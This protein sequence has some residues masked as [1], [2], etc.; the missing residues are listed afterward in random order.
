MDC[1]KTESERPDRKTIAAYVNNLHPVSSVKLWSGGTAEVVRSGSTD[2]GVSGGVRS[3]IK[4]I[5]RKSLARLLFVAREGNGQWRS[6]ITLT[7]PAMFPDNGTKVKADLNRFL[8]WYRRKHAGM[9]LW[10][11]EFQRRGAPHIHMLSEVGEV[12]EVERHY[13]SKAWV[14]AIKLGGVNN[15][16]G[17]GKV[18]AD[19]L[20]QETYYVHSRRVA[21]ED[22]RTEDGAVRYVTKY[23]LKTYQKRVP[24]EFR[25][26]GRFWGCS[27]AVT[28]G[29]TPEL[30][31]EMTDD[32]L[33]AYL[34]GVGHRT[35]EWDI[36]PRY[37]FGFNT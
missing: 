13:F 23:A 24:E 32:E 8:A 20:A 17:L 36:L 33:R 21:W 2:N 35:A 22:V 16:W 7:Y 5:T 14:R 31:I 10:W 37:V 29:I 1:R 30:E 4:M 15:Y 9:Y 3:E 6:M 25:D 27:R 34:S 11:L 28:S 12:S 18:E 19:M 26:V